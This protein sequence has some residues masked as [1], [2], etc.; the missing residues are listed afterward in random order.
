M[1]TLLV[2]PL[3]LLALPLAND[4]IFVIQNR[5]SVA[6]TVAKS[7]KKFR[8]AFAIIIVAKIDL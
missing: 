4:D 7:T 8:C 3:T 5:L 6:R 2:I 1:S